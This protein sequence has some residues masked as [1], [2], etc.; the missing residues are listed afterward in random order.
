[1]PDADAWYIY[2]RCGLSAWQDPYP[3]AEIG[4]PCHPTI[5]AYQATRGCR[6]SDPPTPAAAL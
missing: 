2:Y 6:A 1:M 4:G 5:I 3:D